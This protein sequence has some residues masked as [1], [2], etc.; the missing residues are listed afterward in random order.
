MNNVFYAV[1][2]KNRNVYL[3]CKDDA[4]GFEWV[5]GVK[6]AMWFDS[7]FKAEEFAEKYFKKFKDWEIAETYCDIN[8]V[9]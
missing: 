2:M 3:K 4:P 8:K 7:D 6:E 9:K 1:K 5:N